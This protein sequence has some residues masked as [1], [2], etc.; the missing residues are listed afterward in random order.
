MKLLKFSLSGLLAHYKIPYTNSSKLTYDIPS[1]TSIEGI[2]G[3]I[4]GFDKWDYHIRINRDDLFIGIR[5]NSKI[6]KIMI[7]LNQIDL[8]SPEKYSDKE[9]G[10]IKERTQIPMEHIFKPDYTF[11]IYYKNSNPLYR[12]L[13]DTILKRNSVYPL[14]FGSAYC[15]AQLEEAKE[16][17]FEPVNLIEYERVCSVVPVKDDIDINLSIENQV[18]LKENIPFRRDTDFTIKEYKKV[19]FN[20]AGNNEGLYCKG[21]FCRT[22]EGDIIYLFGADSDK[23]T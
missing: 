23:I 17:D 15:L 4:L 14:C 22:E 16:V 10:L 3:A 8:I 20:P 18:I 19:I 9:Y 5:I 7:T 6:N 12:S 21:N 1:F 11:Y 2:L 13:A